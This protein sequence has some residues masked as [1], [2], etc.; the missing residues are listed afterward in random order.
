[1]NLDDLF[2]SGSAGASP[3][4]D[5]DL[6][7]LKQLLV[8]TRFQDLKAVSAPPAGISDSPEE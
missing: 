6:M 1:M 8:R 7:V 4:H 3:S 5:A 2:S